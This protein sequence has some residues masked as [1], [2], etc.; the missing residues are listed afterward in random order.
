MKQFSYNGTPKKLSKILC[1]F[2]EGFSYSYIQKLIRSGDVKLNGV[3]IKQDDTV[4][5]GEITVYCREQVL[6]AEVIFED[7]NVLIAKKPRGIT[8]E[9]F[10]EKCFPNK[11]LCHRLDTNT[12]GLI[13]FAASEKIFEEIKKC[14]CDHKIEKH[15]AAEVFGK[16]ITAG[17][18]HDYLLKNEKEGRVYIYN[19]PVKGAVPVTTA[20]TVVSK[21]KDTALLDVELVT[22][23]T[24]QIRAHFAYYGHPLVGDGKYGSEKLNREKKTHVQHLCAYKLIFHT[25]KNQLLGYLNGKTVEIPFP[26][27]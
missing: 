6:Q 26:T 21:T 10:A 2:L 19:H 18:Y 4:T 11:I 8:S 3:R 20:F 17:A 14:F 23:K 16:D 9:D 24:H 25:A 15:Y 27:F 22:G 7:E 1:E 13:L 5:G 12:E